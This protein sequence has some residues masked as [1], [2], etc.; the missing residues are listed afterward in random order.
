MRKSTT[1]L[2]K[3]LVSIGDKQE[4]IIRHFVEE[5]RAISDSDVVRQALN[6][7]HDKV[8]PNYI[9]R[10]TPAAKKKQKELDYED[11]Y[12]N[13]TEEDFALS[14]GFHPVTTRD[15]AKL[16]F[17]RYLGHEPRLVPLEGLKD[18]AEQH[19]LELIQNRNEMKYEPV[20]KFFTSA[21]GQ[22][23]VT[24]QNLI[25]PFE[26]PTPEDGYSEV[27]DVEEAN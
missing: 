18:W 27:D 11:E 16:A 3:K 12:E 4:E 25:N 15:G 19:D 13:Q 2:K 8:F 5:G 20:E 26:E 9:F 7:Y 21:W 24:E 10:L 6:Y 17:Y 14:I 1:K 23:F 22:R